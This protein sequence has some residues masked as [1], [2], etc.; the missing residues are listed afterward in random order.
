[1]RERLIGDT[2]YR[3]LQEKNVSPIGTPHIHL[4]E[5]AQNGAF[6]YTA[7]FEIQPEVELKQVKGLKVDKVSANV[8]DEDVAEQLEIMRKQAAQLV[9]VMIRDTVED[10]DIVLVDYE[11]T[12]G[13]IPFKGGKAE[14]AL[15]EVGAEG[16]LKEFQDGLRGA[17]VP[18]ERVVQVDFPADYG[19][20][21]LAGKPATFKI[22]LKELK[23][24]ELPAL[25]DEFARDLGAENLDALKKQ[26][27]DSFA[28]H[29]TREAEAQQRKKL[30]EA[31]VAANPFEVPDSLV[32]EQAERMIAGAHARVQQMVGKRVSLSEE[33]LANLRKDSRVD[34]EFQVRSGLLLLR[35]AETEGL[36]VD[37]AEIDAEIEKM[38]SEAGEHGARVRAA[39]S[40]PDMK[41]RLGYRLLEDKAI[42]YLLSHAQL[43]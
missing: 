11:G 16:Y 4:G 29:K 12:M 19:A 31:L 41:N 27:S 3:A 34:A 8:S 6:S 21:E 13:G 7:E 33:E 18:G 43:S 20:A 40:D 22:R 42:T 2:L 37:N 23:K 35:V 30:L 24:K 14:N 10:G 28:A 17:R 9:P 36:R 25:D 15:I 32:T 5:L 26:V 1:V 39:Y 38:A